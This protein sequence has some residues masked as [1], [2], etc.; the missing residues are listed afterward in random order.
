MKKLSLFLLLLIGTFA[1][2]QI[3]PITIYNF[4]TH[5]VNYRLVGTN[6]N[7]QPIDCQP[8]VEGYSATPL[9]PSNSVSY[10]QYNTSHLGNPPIYEWN[11]ISDAISIPS[12]VYNVSAGAVIPSIITHTTTWQSI[13]LKFDNGEFLQLGRFCGFVDYNQGAFS[14][15]TPSNIT[16]TWNYIGTPGN[17][18]VIVFIN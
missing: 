15:S 10:N 9:T 12:Q 4:S 6:D 3:Y 18:N 2:S 17:G 11:V 16:A 8:I 7:T 14:G 13:D 1:Y 5:N